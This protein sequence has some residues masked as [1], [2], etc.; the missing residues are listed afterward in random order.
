MRFREEIPVVNRAQ[1][2]TCDRVR[3]ISRVTYYF[4][5]VGFDI[6]A[7]FMSQANVEDPLNCVN[8]ITLH[9]EPTL[10]N[11]CGDGWT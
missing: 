3:F 6:E 5:A 10:P 4:E 11:L 2:L 9:F 8:V 1:Y 7:Y